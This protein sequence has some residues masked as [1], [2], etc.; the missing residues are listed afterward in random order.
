MNTKFLGE[1]DE[2]SNFFQNLVSVHAYLL[3][4][5]ELSYDLKLTFRLEII[6][7]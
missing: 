5:S 7:F 3:F 2:N 1:I 4:S 6:M